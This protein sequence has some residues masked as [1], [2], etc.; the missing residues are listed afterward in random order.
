MTAALSIDFGNSYTKVGIRR[1]LNEVSR[2]LSSE[3]D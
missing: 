1:E 2:L 3:E